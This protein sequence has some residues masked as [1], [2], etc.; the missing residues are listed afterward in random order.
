MKRQWT[1]TVTMTRAFLVVFEGLKLHMDCMLLQSLCDL[2]E[3]LILKLF[4]HKTYWHSLLVVD[5]RGLN[6]PGSLPLSCRTA[7]HC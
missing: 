1:K 4:F 5:L 7:R 6:P 2:S 3:I